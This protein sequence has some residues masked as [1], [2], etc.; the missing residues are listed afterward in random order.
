MSVAGS[1][2][3]KASAIAGADGKWRVKL[4]TPAAGGPYTISIRTTDSDIRINDILIGEVWVAS[5][6]SNMDIPLKGWSPGDTIFNSAVEIANATFPA[7]RFMK[8]PFSWIRVVW[9]YLKRKTFIFSTVNR[10]ILRPRD[11]NSSSKE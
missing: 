4:A 1:W 3:K 9:K 2:G 6:Q 8:V 11:N 10:D 5:G 7:I